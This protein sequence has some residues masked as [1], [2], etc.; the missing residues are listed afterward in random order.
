VRPGDTVF[1]T[2]VGVPAGQIARLAGLR[3]QLR[4]AVGH[5]VVAR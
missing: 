5:G 2:A 4:E 1:V 3:D